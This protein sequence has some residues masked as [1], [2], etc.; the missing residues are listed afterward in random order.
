MQ[1]AFVDN[2]FTYRPNEIPEDRVAT[3]KEIGYD[4]SQPGLWCYKGELG[5]GAYG[6]ATLW[7]Q[8]D[9]QARHIN[10]QVLKD[11]YLIDGRWNHA[12]YWAGN[13]DSRKP[14][15]FEIVTQLKAL[16]GSENIVEYYETTVY[17]EKTMYR[18]YME[19][20]EHGTL[21]DL[22][23]AHR[24]AQELQTAEGTAVNWRIS[25]R[26]L[27]CIF[28]GLASALCLAHQ[29]RLPENTHRRPKI[30]P[31]IHRDIKPA[32]ILLAAPHADVWPELPIVKLADWGLVVPKSTGD[33]LTRRGGTAA[34]MAPEVLPYEGSD[35]S[36]YGHHEPSEASDIW[37]LG[38]VMLALANLDKANVKPFRF[39]MAPP[40]YGSGVQERL[41]P[42]MVA[43]I[44]QC[45]ETEPND[46]IKC[47]VLWKNI[48][49][50]VAT[51]KGPFGQPM[52]MKKREEDE[53]LLYQHDKYRAWGR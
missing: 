4:G 18:I 43:L 25:P 34:W 45:L 12:A 41:P 1:K 17:A 29:G 53:V 49:A 14:V 10:R 51:F 30:V 9:A 20:A 50:Q 33:H 38:R 47:G 22:M 46:R 28:E 6:T 23:E 32:N 26:L 3:A 39:G 21:Q 42:R 44:D 36:L 16:P 52:K 2:D 11:T 7:V 35:H 48:Q 24:E 40:T 5:A 37:S 15:E 27:W 13:I 19:Y 31:V 8:L